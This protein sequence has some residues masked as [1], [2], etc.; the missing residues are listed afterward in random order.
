MNYFLI[1]V[2]RYKYLFI[3]N[4]VILSLIIIFPMKELKSKSISGLNRIGIILKPDIIVSQKFISDL[5]NIERI[6]LMISTINKG[7]KCDINV[8]LYDK[9]HKLLGTK[10][11]NNE[12]VKYVLENDKMTTDYFNYYLKNPIKNALNK[13]FYIEVSTNCDNIVR[14]QY[15]DALANDD[16]AIYDGLETSKK[17][18]LRYSGSKF[19][20]NNI[21][22]SIVLFIIS[23]IIILGGKNENK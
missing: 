5:D 6:S 9:N 15:Y 21:L 10:K 19:S 23:L 7:I 14:L 16:I 11:F 2:K 1:I 4:L 18:A 13:K 20:I 22:Y 3:I 17:L 12:N 8:N